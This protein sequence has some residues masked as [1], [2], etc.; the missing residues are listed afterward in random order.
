MD[1]PLESRSPE[2][3]EQVNLRIMFDAL[4]YDSDEE[5]W[6]RFTGASSV[7][8]AKTNDDVALVLDTIE[9]ACS[10]GK[11]AV[12][13]VS[14]EAASAFDSALVHHPAGSL[15]LAAFAIFDQAEEGCPGGMEPLS[16]P[17]D[18]APVIGESN[19][20]DSIQQIKSYLR[21]GDSYQVNFTHRLKG[22]TTAS[23]ASIFSFLCRAQPSP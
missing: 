23:P 8:I 4:I 1:K 7:H 2:G 18:L 20:G 14:F 9:T 22:K 19:F 13:Y 15:P 5:A 12:G 16:E 11:Y 10:E 3:S 17:L 6:L 21:S